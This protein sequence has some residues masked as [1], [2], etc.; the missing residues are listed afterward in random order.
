MHHYNPPSKSLTQFLSVR[1]INLN[2]NEHN[3]LVKRLHGGSTNSRGGRTHEVLFWDTE[4]RKKKEH[5]WQATA[6]KED[7]TRVERRNT[8]VSQRRFIKTKAASSS[9]CDTRVSFNN[10]SPHRISYTNARM[11]ARTHCCISGPQNYLV[12]TEM[13]H[14][15]EYNPKL[16]VTC[17]K[18]TF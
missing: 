1:V 8:G 7:N 10:F 3:L 17:G 16:K 6:G 15:L 2:K 13:S 12:L 14:G 4:A 9:R 11:Y 18:M 5:D